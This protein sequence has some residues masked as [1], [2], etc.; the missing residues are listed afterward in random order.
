MTAPLGA[1][2][3]LQI[4]IVAVLN[5]SADLQSLAGN[6]PRIYQDVPTNFALPYITVGEGNGNDVSVLGGSITDEYAKIDVWGKTFRE[7]KQVA[8]VIYERLHEGQDRLTSLSEY[9]CSSLQLARPG[10]QVMR[11]PDG[12]T[13]H[14]S[15]T[16]AAHLSPR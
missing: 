12:V 7:A 3:D 4:A 13:K 1:S 9:T 6:P 15:M 14:V 16:F 5:A 10:S 11:D 2:L 8:A